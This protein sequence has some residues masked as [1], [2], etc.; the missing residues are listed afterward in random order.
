MVTVCGNRAW[1]LN[2][3]CVCVRVCVC[4]CQV[5]DWER[6][7][8]RLSSQPGSALRPG[9][10]AESYGTEGGFVNNLVAGDEDS[11]EFDDLIFALKTGEQICPGNTQSVCVCAALGVRHKASGCGCVCVCLSVC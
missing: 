3:A 11:Q 6:A 2:R 8:L 7:S 5:S 9:P 10:V 1:P 4:V